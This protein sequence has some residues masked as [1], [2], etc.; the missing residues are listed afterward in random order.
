[1][2]G[3]IVPFA[4]LQ[5]YVFFFS[6]KP[7]VF[8]LVLTLVIISYLAIVYLLLNSF[9]EIF[10]AVTTLVSSKTKIS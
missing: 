8:D 5:F 1:M 2:L 3:S 9:P 4:L 6:V 7:A 10:N